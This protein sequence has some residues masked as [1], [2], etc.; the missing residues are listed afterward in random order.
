MIEVSG[1][2]VR[3]G[4]VT[5]L[6]D[7]SVVVDE[8]ECVAVLG[9]NGAG[10]TSLLRAISGFTPAVAGEARFD[11]RSVLGERPENIVRAGMSHVPEGRGVL[12][13]LTVEENL[14]LATAPWRRRGEPIDDDLARVHELFP[15]LG[16]RSNQ[17]A[18]SLS[19][20][21]QQML[22]IGRALMARPR[23]MLLDEP[24]LGLAPVI[25]TRVFDV[26]EEIARDNLTLLVV[27]Q[28][29]KQAMRVADRVYVLSQGRVVLE[30]DAD[31]LR[32]DPQM[33]EAYFGV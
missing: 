30:G 3:Y 12:G 10:K 27:E 29:A 7:V 15:I 11:G 2:A 25:V 8:G 31:E 21:E 33:A 4:A 16:E 28:N 17:R 24:S 18:I 9:A 19:G 23:V 5:A 22:A 14:E 13:Q 6:Q 26:L 32:D 1:L 20:G